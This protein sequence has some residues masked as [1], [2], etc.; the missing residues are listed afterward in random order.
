[1]DRLTRC[2]LEIR[3]E[4]LRFLRRRRGL[5]EAEDVLQDTWLR[6]R[7][8]GDPLAWREPRAVLF[9]TAANLATDAGRREVLA[10][11][12]LADESSRT[13][14]GQEHPDP[15]TELE[16]ASQLERVIA[17]LEQLPAPCREAFLLSRI[18][19]LTHAQIARRLGVSAKSVQ[20]YIERAM[21]HCLEVTDV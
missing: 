6:L 15:Q 4:L 13:S 12:W 20:R 9:R 16:A 3:H 8:R 18:D 14:D 10:N 11:K 19:S 1:M 17:A 7:E 2:F 21:L 5:L